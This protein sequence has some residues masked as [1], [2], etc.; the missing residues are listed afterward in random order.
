MCVMV[1][2][3]CTAGQGSTDKHTAGRPSAAATP[4]GHGTDALPA[5]PF[6]SV[7]FK[8]PLGS[9]DQAPTEEEGMSVLEVRLH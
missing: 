3:C 4:P 6:A 5:T 9:A 2:L 8:Q 1:C 7:A